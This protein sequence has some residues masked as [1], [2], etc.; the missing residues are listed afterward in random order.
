MPLCIEPFEKKP[1]RP[2]ANV[3]E[4]LFG[5]AFSDVLPEPDSAPMPLVS[6][7]SSW[8]FPWSVM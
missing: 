2:P 3:F 4:P 7:C 6:S 1:S 8:M 5:I